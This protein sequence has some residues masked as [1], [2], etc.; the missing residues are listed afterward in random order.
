MLNIKMDMDI[1]EEMESNV[2]S[3]IRSFP[4]IFETAENAI[5]WD[6]NGGRYIDFFAGAG[7]LNYGHNNAEVTESLIEYLRNKGIIQS[8]DMAT[9]A[10][11]DFLRNFSEIILFPKKYE[12]KVQF[13]GPT[14]TNAIEAALK[15][16]RLAKKRSNILAFTNG[17]HGL[18]LG[19]LATTANEFYHNPNYGVR[20]NVTRIPFDG[21]FGKNINTIQYIEKILTDRGSG[22]DFPAAIIVE[23]IQCEGG[24]NV[25]SPQWLRALSGLCQ[26]LDILLI[27]DDIQ[28]GNGRTGKFFSFEE[29][30][31]IPDMIC[32]SKSIGGGL[33]M[34][35]L[36]LKPYL[37]KWAPGEHTGTFRGNNLAFLA[38]NKLLKYWTN[39]VLTKE[40]ECKS[41][42]IK[43]T[44]LQ[45]AKA[46]PNKT[47][48]VRGR[49]MVW[50]I[51][52]F[53]KKLAHSVVHNSFQKGLLIETCGS[54]GQVIKIIP[55]LTIEKEIL[56]EGLN[57][58]TEALKK[59]LNNT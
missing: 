42:I 17:Y 13:T 4:T 35:L 51:D 38:A 43:N 40:I 25:A 37:D 14:G 57:I 46:S 27:V 59:S 23:T 58:F 30:G 49:G 11:R 16:A 9:V 5:L 36:L 55:P 39:D 22:I 20:N 10:K 52:V 2:R 47:F 15:L 44:L 1:F 21:Y 3:Y 7:S 41:D 33:P 32:L 18:T 56:V 34:A 6:I 8:L 29:S 53:Q 24:I 12:Y 19:A 48:N 50:G 26:K 28:V 54:E 31:I 45:F